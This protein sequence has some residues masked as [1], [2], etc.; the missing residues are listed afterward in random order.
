MTAI[1]YGYDQSLWQKYWQDAAEIT[2][3]IGKGINRFHSVYWIGMLLSAGVRLPNTIFVHG[4]IT[5]E[6]QKMS[7]SLGNVI[8]PFELVD[9]FGLEPVRYYLLK[10]IPAH[11]DGDFSYSRFKELYTADLANGLGNLCSRVAKLCQK[12]G[13]SFDVPKVEAFDAS[14]SQLFE[15]YE[16]SQAAGWVVEQI[17]EA[18]QFLSRTRPWTLSGDDQHKVLIEAVQRI[19]SIA[20]HLQP[21]M[22]KTANNILDHFY[23][24]QISALEPLFPRLD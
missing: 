19:T 8:D 13:E 23:Q 7:K 9:Q 2:H 1:G 20:Y 3:V 11:S 16:T 5:A 21:F 4:Y 10:E 6:G 17:A 18:D 22:P 14:F 12:S 15:A 24:D